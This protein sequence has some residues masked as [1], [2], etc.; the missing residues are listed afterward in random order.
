MPSRASKND[1]E[2]ARKYDK[3]RVRAT[4]RLRAMHKQQYATLLRE[5]MEAQ[6]EPLRRS[7]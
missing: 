6:G 4:Q 5:E 7:S 2:Y 1:I 3:A